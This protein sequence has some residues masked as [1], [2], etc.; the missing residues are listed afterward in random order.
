MKVKQQ[1]VLLN[2]EE[3]IP[4]VH[5]ISNMIQFLPPLIPIKMKTIQ[6]ISDAFNKELIEALRSGS[7]KQ[8]SMINIIRGKIIYYAFAINELVQKTVH[9][10]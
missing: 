8:D 5:N 10:K 7:T 4:D 6:N 2:V 3:T 1:Y 9:K